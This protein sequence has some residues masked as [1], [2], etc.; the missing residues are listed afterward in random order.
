MTTEREAY[1]AYLEKR[2]QLDVLREYAQAVSRATAG[3]GMTPV[4]PLATMGENGPLLCDH[5]K[6]P[7]IL[8]GGRYNRVNADAAWADP[9][10]P[11]PEDTWRSYISG[12]MVVEIET[13]GTLRIFHGYPNGRGHCCTLAET[14]RREAYAKH[15]DTT[16]RQQVSK[17]FLKQEL[18]ALTDAERDALWNDIWDVLCSFDPGLG[19]NRPPR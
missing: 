19:I 6:K 4:K 10:H 9:G 2:K 11:Q 5:C 1:A 17:A 7:M 12:G 16:P 18:P 15:Q 3:S 13:N 8:E 14:A